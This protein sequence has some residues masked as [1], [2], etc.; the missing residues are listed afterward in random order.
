MLRPILCL[1]MFTTLALPQSAL[2]APGMGD[3]VY[4]AEIETGKVELESRYGAL[5]GG[6]ADG[7]DALK[8]EAAYSVN[9]R[10]RVAALGEFEHTPGSARKATAMGIEAIYRLGK[11]GD[12]SVALYGEYEVAFDGADKVETKLILQRRKGPLDLRFNLIAEK[13]LDS[14]APVE[15]GYAASADY[16]VIGDV[17]LGARAFGELG[18]FN[19]AFPYAEHYVGPVAKVEFEPF[20]QEIELEAGYLFAVGKARQDT[21]GQVRVMLGVE[22]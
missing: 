15:L 8:L 12:V 7:E 16:R 4:G 6:P 2:A 21:K 9:D 14:H 3:E 10:L 13:P 11:V 19:R 1:A 5:A 20:G 18:T 17:S 22:F